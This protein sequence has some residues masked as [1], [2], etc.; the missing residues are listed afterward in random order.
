MDQVWALGQNSIQH[1]I[2]LNSWASPWLCLAPSWRRQ[3]ASAWQR[4]LLSATLW[5]RRLPSLC[6]AAPPSASG[7]V[8]AEERD[9][10]ART[11]PDGINMSIS[12]TCTC[13]TANMQCDISLD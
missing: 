4:L 2:Q 5:G 12:T 7:A 8:A 1:Q 9:L 13:Y 10:Q 3:Q 11:Q 6:Q